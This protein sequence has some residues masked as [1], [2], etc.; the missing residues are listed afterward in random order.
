VDVVT[1]ALA[2]SVDRIVH[3]T[4]GARADGIAEWCNARK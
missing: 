1:A 4:F 3:V 2:R